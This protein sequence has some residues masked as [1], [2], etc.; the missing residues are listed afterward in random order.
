M[1]IRADEVMD[2]DIDVVVDGL[3]SS[4]LSTFPVY[5]QDTLLA[6][7]RHG[8]QRRGHSFSDVLDEIVDHRKIYRLV[9]SNGY[10]VSAFTAF[11][12]CLCALHF[13]QS[14]QG[15]WVLVLL[16]NNWQQ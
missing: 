1:R 11:N 15:N 14:P 5:F 2:M 9:Q 10:R 3:R 16:P 12:S 6:V 13:P 4:S 7:W 8:W